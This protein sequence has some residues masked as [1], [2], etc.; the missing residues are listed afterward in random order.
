MRAALAAN[1]DPERLL[2][3][4][5]L[6]ELFG[7]GG[8]QAARRTLEEQERRPRFELR[9]LGEQLLIPLLEGSEVFFLLFGK[10][11]EHQAAATILRHRR[12]ARV[13][14]IGRAHV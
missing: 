5:A 9:I 14:Q 4:D 13:K 6:L 11:L 8:K 2:I 7:A 1:A 10:A 3:V 12:G